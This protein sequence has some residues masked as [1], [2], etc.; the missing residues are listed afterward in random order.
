MVGHHQNNGVIDQFLKGH[1]D[2]LESPHFLRVRRRLQVPV[3]DGLLPNKRKTAQIDPNETVG[4][5]FF[6]WL[7]PKKRKTPKWGS[8]TSIWFRPPKKE[9]Q[10]CPVVTPSLL[11]QQGKITH[12]FIS[13]NGRDASDAPTPTT[14]RPTP[15]RPSAAAPG[16]PPRR[17]DGPWRPRRL[18]KGGGGTG[19]IQG[20][21]AKSL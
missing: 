8:G 11:N 4:T 19:C 2:C 13:A 9:K 6:W 10:L 1:G 16:A 14:L 12:T 5:S 21:G 7:Y 15:R 3:F 20:T 17:A 18:G